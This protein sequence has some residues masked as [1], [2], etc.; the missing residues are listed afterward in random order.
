M[1]KGKRKR[2]QYAPKVRGNRESLMDEHTK[3]VIE[4][5][6]KIRTRMRVRD[7]AGNERLFRSTVAE[8]PEIP[9]D[10]EEEGDG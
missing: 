3:A 4:E 8:N 7:C 9:E 5:A 6:I 1:A 10:A 2:R